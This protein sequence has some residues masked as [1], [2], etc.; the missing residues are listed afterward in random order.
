MSS[1]RWA[2]GRA[3][4][5]RV[6][7]VEGPTPGAFIFRDAVPERIQEIGWLQP[8]FATASGKLLTSVHALVIESEGRRILV[9]T[10]IGND[11]QRPAIPNWHLRQGSFLRDLVAAGFPP[12][13]IDTVVC[14]HLHVDHVGWNTMLVGNRWVPTFR[15]ARYLIGA[16]EWAYW[17]DHPDPFGGDIVGDSIR[18]VLDAGLVDLVASDHRITDEVRLVAT[19]GH[20]PGH[21]S[22]L[23]FSAGEEAIITGDV[24]HHPCQMAHPEW[25]SH[26][27]ADRAAARATRQEFLARYA[28]QPTLV[29]GTHFASPAAGRIVRDGETFR[30]QV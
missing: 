24:M 18:P 20:T 19:H 7:E 30:Y 11:K 8:H 13:S 5:T 10:C 15:R 25:A 12:E 29:L 23:I 28:D 6:V 17:E 4:I 2:I 14:T 3:R 1:N 27:D 26:F 16:E 9:D 22:V 21:V